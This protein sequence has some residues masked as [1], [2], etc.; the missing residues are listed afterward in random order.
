[1]SGENANIAKGS[2]DI[3]A[4]Y[5]SGADAQNT[6][7]QSLNEQHAQ[8]TGG[9]RQVG[10]G[11]QTVTDTYSQPGR[12][13]SVNKQRLATGNRNTAR[14][15]PLAPTNFSSRGRSKS[16]PTGTRGSLNEFKPVDQS[17]ESIK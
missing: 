14:L 3:S 12:F 8:L 15:A 11:H 10:R 4:A 16:R 5:T 2:Q 7:N 1:M 6:T 9:I 17:V 13:G